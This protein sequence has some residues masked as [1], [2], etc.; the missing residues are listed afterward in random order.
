VLVILFHNIYGMMELFGLVIIS[1]EGGFE[2]VTMDRI[3][4]LHSS[5]KCKWW[6]VDIPILSFL[7]SYLLPLFD[8]LMSNLVSLSI[9]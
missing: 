8:L 4:E 2:F 3:K 5:M 7:P 9:L 1:S 6:N